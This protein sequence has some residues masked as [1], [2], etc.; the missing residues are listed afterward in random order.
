MRRDRDSGHSTEKTARPV[1]AAKTTQI[2]R[3][4]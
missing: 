3:E 1:M 4:V 2:I